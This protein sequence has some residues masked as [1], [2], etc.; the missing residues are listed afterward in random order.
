MWREQI[1]EAKKAKNI[2]TKMMSEKV[3]LPEQTIARILSGKTA[4]PRIDTVLD[5]GAAVGLTPRELFSDTTSVLGDENLVVLQG[6]LD[7]ANV[8]LS[9]LQT[10]FASLSAENT[11]LKVKNVS[12]QAENDLLRIKL[13]HKEEIISLHN[14][15]NSMI[16][17]K[18]QGN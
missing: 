14:Y 2:T 18:E 5:L 7:E 6:K 1:I 8:A 17:K 13:E 9:A 10:E 4:T 12:L 16:M 3:R 11:D 15:Y